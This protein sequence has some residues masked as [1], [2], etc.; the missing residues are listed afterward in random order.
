MSFPAPW[1]GEKSLLLLTQTTCVRGLLA[2][3]Q[4]IKSDFSCSHQ[5]ELIRLLPSDGTQS[6]SFGE[7]DRGSMKMRGLPPCRRV[8][9][10]IWGL[11]DAPGAGRG[12]GAGTRPHL[13]RGR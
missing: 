5:L 13:C 10:V 4:L 7:S 9:L 3:A 2:K 12:S 8:Y 1:D 6:L 11:V